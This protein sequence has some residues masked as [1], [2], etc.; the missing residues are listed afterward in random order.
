MADG[1]R[2]SGGAASSGAGSSARPLVRDAAGRA[3]RRAER[4][5]SPAEI[6]R[7]GREA[8]GQ[9]GQSCRLPRRSPS[10]WGR[11]WFRGVVGLGVRA[12][13]AVPGRGTRL[14]GSLGGR[15]ACR[16]G[17]DDALS[18]RRAARRHPWRPPRKK[19]L[20]AAIAPLLPSILGVRAGR[21]SSE[22]M[23]FDRRGSAINFSCL[24][25]QK[26]VSD[27]VVPAL[28]VSTDVMVYGE[29]VRERY[30]L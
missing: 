20:L 15:E 9:E 8:C 2:L 19:D 12:S 3:A 18:S 24:D 6:A 16:R 4:P 29:E 1:G 5:S 26:K 7:G 27:H 14:V 13:P 30:G 28:L 22:D 17:E 21:F 25:R 11:G 23:R 10:S